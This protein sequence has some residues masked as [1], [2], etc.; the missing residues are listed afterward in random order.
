MKE[1]IFK[2]A[3]RKDGVIYTGYRHYLI[4]HD[5]LNRGVCSKPFP[6]GVDQAFITNFGRWVSREE[7]LEIALRTGQ[8]NIKNKKGGSTQL[9]SEDLWTVNGEPYYTEDKPF[10]N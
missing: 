7:A 5:M 3:I 2:A 9:F 6:G 4:G 1:I 8:L 10:T